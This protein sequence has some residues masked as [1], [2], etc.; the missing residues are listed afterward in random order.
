VHYGREVREDNERGITIDE[1]LSLDF[2]RSILD[3]VRAII[4][5]IEKDG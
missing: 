2:A 4:G 1:V 5:G 3:V